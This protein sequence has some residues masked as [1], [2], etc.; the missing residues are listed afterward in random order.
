MQDKT[1]PSDGAAK[2]PL[3]ATCAMSSHR[4]NLSNWI[5]FPAKVYEILLYVSG[6]FLGPNRYLLN[7]QNLFPV[8]KTTEFMK[9][10]IS[11]PHPYTY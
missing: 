8:A 4:N 2:V 1:R 7:R 5:R 10:I 11:T 9:R 6:T 3:A